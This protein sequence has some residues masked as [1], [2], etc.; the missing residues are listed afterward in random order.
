MPSAPESIT[1]TTQ[2]KAI[3]RGGPELDDLERLDA[4]ATAGHVV[5]GDRVTVRVMASPGAL[6]PPAVAHLRIGDAKEI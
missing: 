4:G 5:R 3:W 1:L 2:V 6:T